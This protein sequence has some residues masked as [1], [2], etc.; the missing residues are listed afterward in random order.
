MNP[1]LNPRA[2][3]LLIGEAPAPDDRGYPFSGSSGQELDFLLRDVELSRVDISLTN[4]FHEKIPNG[5]INNWAVPRKEL[6]NLIDPALPWNVI[7]CKKGVVDPRILQPAL[8]RLQDE[9]TKAAPHVIGALGNSPLAAL[10]GVSGITKLRG[11]LHFY[12]SIKVIPTYHPGY[13]LRNYEARPS[14]VADFQKIKLESSSPF[15]NLINRKIYLDPSKED[16][17][18]WVSRLCSEPYL[19]CDIE[20]KARQITC[21]GF[22]PNKAEAFVIPLWTPKGNYWDH[23]GEVLAYKAIK[24]ICEADNIKIFQ[25]GIYDIQYLIKYK[26]KVR[27]F[28]E[29]T[30]L[31]HHSLYPA[32]QKGLDFL[33]SV[34]A[35]ERAWKRWRLRGD[36]EFK[37][38]E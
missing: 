35:N 3:I 21:M 14:V 15:A 37:K 26:I 8:K 4:L 38:D 30:M 17:S 16:L 34:Y 27:N 11:A 10:C 7:P 13:V 6:K 1:I 19:A 2:R 20:T 31:L 29:D 23:E 32:L 22:A 24:Q 33:G 5:D 36:E 25:N 18:S 28:S 9:I 12:N